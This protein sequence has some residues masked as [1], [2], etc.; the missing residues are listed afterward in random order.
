MNIA[1]AGQS[2]IAYHHFCV[3]Y[4]SADGK[5]HS[6]YKSITLE[7]GGPAPDP[8]ALEERARAAS[9]KLVSEQLKLGWDNASIK[10]LMLGPEAFEKPG[11]VKVDLKTRKF[12][13]VD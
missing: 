8:K 7:G 5:V 6:I 1:Q 10:S 11:P 12:V 13:P 2:R 4:N 3:L 9:E